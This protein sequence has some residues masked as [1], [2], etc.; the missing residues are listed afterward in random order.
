MPE[1]A[2]HLGGNM[3]KILIAVFAGLLLL[4]SIGVHAEIGV[5]IQLH[6]DQIASDLTTGMLRPSEAKIVANQLDRIKFEYKRAKSDGVI[7]N[8]ER[9]VLNQM[10]LENAQQFRKYE[11]NKLKK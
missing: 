9:Q 11:Q 2:D 1:Q 10:L 8:Y 4:T 3:R 7:N 5:S 6:Q